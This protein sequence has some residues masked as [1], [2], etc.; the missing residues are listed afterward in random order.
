MKFYDN[1][2]NPRYEASPFAIDVD[3]T[4]LFYT[5]TDATPFIL[6]QSGIVFGVPGGEHDDIESRNK[7]KRPLI[8]GRWW[9]K[10][11]ALVLWECTS[12]YEVKCSF[13][14][15]FVGTVK[16]FG[17][18]GMG[19]R[20]FEDFGRFREE[21]GGRRMQIVIM[22]TTVREYLSL[23]IQEK[24]ENWFWRTF[25]SQGKE[26]SLGGN[27]TKNGMGS[28]DVW[29]H[30]E[31][32]ELKTNMKKNVVKINETDLRYMVSESVKRI[33]KEYDERE[34][35]DSEEGLRFKEELRMEKEREKRAE[36]ERKR[37][38]GLIPKLTNDE[39][40][41]RFMQSAC[42]V[43]TNMLYYGYYGHNPE[44]GR[45]FL[46][47]IY[48]MYNEAGLNSNSL[49]PESFLEAFK[50][51]NV[52]ILGVSLDAC[53]WLKDSLDAYWAHLYLGRSWGSMEAGFDSHNTK[54]LNLNSVRRITLR[55]ELEY[56][57]AKY[58]NSL[59][60]VLNYN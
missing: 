7:G 58:P 11:N 6:Y 31:I 26:K 18:D 57:K 14:K 34:F 45:K 32:T 25:D 16:K 8:R 40:I 56:L 50:K 36:I 1:I 23:N 38:E 55:E 10:A 24:E 20:F 13:L 49:S 28:R 4:H 54:N 60:K 17:I 30:Y 27:I 3:G 43:L 39:K 33:L 12:S 35:W 47:V 46:N 42:S 15:K 22:E 29:R 2:K 37:K 59:T 52:K 41:M 9:V 51:T 53:M 21:D 44:T 48:E 5:S 19:I